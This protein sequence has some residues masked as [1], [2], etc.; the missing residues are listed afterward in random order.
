MGAERRL[1]SSPTPACQE[2]VRLR[3][4]AI[5]VK[6]RDASASEKPGEATESP[7]P[8]VPEWPRRRRLPLA[9]SIAGL[10][11]LTLGVLSTVERFN[12]SRGTSTPASAKAP[13]FQRPLSN[14]A[15]RETTPSLSP[16]GEHVVYF[17]ERPG[18]E[19]LY[20]R[21]IA[22]GPAKRLLLT[23]AR[24][25]RPSYPKWSPRGDLI[26][27]LGRE[28]QEEVRS[29]YVVS[30][31][32]GLPRKLTS[33]AGIGLCWSPDGH[34]L[35]FVDRHSSA[36]P[37]SIFLISLETGQRR[38]ITMPPAGSFGDTH[39][40]FS[41]DGRRLAVSRFFTRYQSDLCVISWLEPDPRVERLT[42]DFEGIEGLQ[43]S[44]DGGDIVFGSYGGLWRIRASPNGHQ[45]PVLITAHGDSAAYPTFSH[46][47]SGDPVL[48]YQRMTTD[49]NIWRWETGGPDAKSMTR[50]TTS[51]GWEDHP[52]LSADGGRLAFVSNQTGSAEIWTANADGSNPRQLTFHDGP[53]PSSPRW[54]PDGRR[55]AYSSHV[56]GNR[57]IY[58]VDADG[59]KSVRITWEPSQE[60]NPSWS[61]DGRW[62][63]FRSDRDGIGQI[64]KVSLD[65][66]R[67][68]R[69]T[70]S[71][72]SQGFESPDGKLLYFVRSIDVPGLWSVSVDGGEERFVLSDVKESLWGVAQKGIAFVATGPDVALG[73]N[74][75]RFFD[76]SSGA[77]STLLALPS[78][79]TT[80]FAVARDGRSI[81]WTRIDS[82]QSD[83]IL[84]DHWK[85]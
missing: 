6:T 35:A 80:G 67:A 60:E 53:I 73:R 20:V 38:R 63:Y 77:T 8:Q 18:A 84:I 44:P 19:G 7:R 78:R 31:T 1:A 2:R 69:V 27:F 3:L 48:V 68:V 32:G 40:A 76:F 14:E 43:W 16:S 33:I 74:I 85:P 22:G 55:L 21:A 28:E 13:I 9:A 10:V 24:V 75:V 58:V 26:A 5:P 51:T 82:S 37:L 64:W 45:N 11:L 30:S 81:L 17:W 39:C 70:T 61:G 52:T 79:A 47:R 83:L 4:Q 25:V 46:P 65:G 34:S 42:Y 41:P 15:E 23:D 12:S 56:G 62:I 29:L 71:E 66:G 50:I 59:T 49:L 54:S 36:E 57:D 72:A